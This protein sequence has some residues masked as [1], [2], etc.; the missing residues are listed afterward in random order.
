M[1]PCNSILPIT[2]YLHPVFCFPTTAFHAVGRFAKTV[3]LSFSDK[4]KKLEA[5]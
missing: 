5:I 2:G 1:S 4:V 3:N